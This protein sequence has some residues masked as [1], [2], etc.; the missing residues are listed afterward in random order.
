[1]KKF[2]FSLQ[3]LLN[4]KE[5]VFDAEMTTLAEM[6]AVLATLEGEL[7]DMQ[8]ERKT[9]Y[10][11]FTSRAARGIAAIEME[12][13]KNYITML[14]FATKQKQN[15]IEMQQRAVDKQ[16]EKVFECKM[17]ISTMEKLREKKLEEYNSM[18]AKAEEIFIEEFVTNSKALK[19]G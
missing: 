17:E 10:A 5:Q 16:A 3:K 9:R 11:D 13:H 2:S 8:T 18:V 1:M 6:R 12:T 14:D 19:A 15:Q 7:A 4:Y